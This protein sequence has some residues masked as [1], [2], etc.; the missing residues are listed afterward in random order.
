MSLGKS[1][2]GAMGFYL[3]LNII[4]TI[5]YA[6]IGGYTGGI[7]GFFSDMSHD[8]FGF[9]SVILGP[10]GGAFNQGTG[11]MDPITVVIA[12]IYSISEGTEVAV[13]VVALLWAILPGFISAII[14]GSK[15]SEDNSKTAFT[16]I[17]L[18]ILLMTMIPWLFGI[19]GQLTPLMSGHTI[20]ATL[21]HAMYLQSGVLL[22]VGPIIHGLFSG[23]I[24]AGVGA[25]IASNL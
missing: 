10:G 18:G 22:Y 2:G 8:T 5:I 17:V 21:T 14:V 23:F 1:L 12:C 15:F 25:A 16:G 19:V 6:G 24:Y 20:T 11:F 13:S 7:S 4:F 9:L 3:I